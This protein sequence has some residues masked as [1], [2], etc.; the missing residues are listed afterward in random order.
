MSEGLEKEREEERRKRRQE[1]R[2]VTGGRPVADCGG[3]L[4]MH[5]GSAF[6][7][8]VCPGASYACGEAGRWQ[9]FLLTK[10]RS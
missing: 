8:T 9:Y 5:P 7:S 2:E 6:K 1:G 10:G 4:F 3:I